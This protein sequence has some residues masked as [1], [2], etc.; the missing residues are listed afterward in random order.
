MT[1]LLA[2]TRSRAA[3]PAGRH[4]ALMVAVQ[5]GR[6]AARSGL[7][8]GVVF[9]T[10]VVVQTLAYTSAY[11]TQAARD[12]MA[13]A[14]GTNIGLNALIG[15]ARAINTVAGYSSWRLLGILSILGSI[16]G[17]LTATRLLR[18]DEESGR[19][20]LL[21][22]GQTTLRRAGAQVLGGLGAGLLT[23]FLL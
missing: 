17:L 6:K 4:P 3:E 16:W 7:L 13:R 21:L 9:A 8:W 11:P 19:Y 14:Y 2:G 18:G 10:Y 12:Q 5:V 20:E 23:L 15:P 1:D 22:A